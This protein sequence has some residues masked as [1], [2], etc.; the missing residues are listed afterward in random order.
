MH[1]HKQQA[2][3]SRTPANGGSALLTSM[4]IKYQISNCYKCFWIPVDL[5]SSPTNKK[6]TW[7]CWRKAH[8]LYSVPA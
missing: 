3:N 4:K 8:P 2:V 7:A 6:I 1:L 5:C